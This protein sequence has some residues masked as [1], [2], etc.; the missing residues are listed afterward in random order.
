MASSILFSGFVAL[1]LTPA[2]C[3]LILTKE[4]ENHIKLGWLGRMLQRFNK[5]FNVGSKK[6]AHV[7]QHT[8]KHKLLT[9]GVVLVFCALAYWVNMG[10]PSGFIPQEDQGMI[11]AVIET[12][13]GSTIERT[14][15]VAHQLLKIAE[16]EDGV[17]SVSSLAGFEILS[18]GTSANSG[19]CLIN[20]KDWKHRKRTAKEI[21]RDLEDKCK[22][23]TTANIDFFEPPSIPGYG[24]ARDRKSVV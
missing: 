1:T 3:A 15:E 21:I 7:L 17:E 2:L 5:Q 20:L 23:I 10:L 4:Q 8:V 12:P 9:M 11:Y 16:K 24:A 22:A 14:N 6:Y 18:E 19:S 13:P